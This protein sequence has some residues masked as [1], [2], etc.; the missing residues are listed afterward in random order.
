MYTRS[1]R[2]RSLI[3]KWQETRHLGLKKQ[4]PY[5]YFK[6][7]IFNIHICMYLRLYVFLLSTFQHSTISLLEL[8]DW[9]LYWR[10]PGSPRTSC[11]CAGG[12]GSTPSQVQVA[13][14]NKYYE[15]RLL[16]VWVADPDQRYFN[17]I[18]ISVIKKFF[19][20]LQF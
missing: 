1:F 9:S 2:I 17:R 6:T 18:K 7:Q 15:C 10:R 16:F 12:P 19:L 4:P 14:L 11:W 13:I 8:P 5:A 3:E 20:R